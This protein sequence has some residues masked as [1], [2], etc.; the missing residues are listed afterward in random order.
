MKGLAIGGVLALLASSGVG[1]QAA[2]D[3][4]KQA[5]LYYVACLRERTAM[6]DDKVSDA[7]TI[8]AVVVPYCRTR[9][10]AYMQSVAP[11]SQVTDRLK[12]PASPA[13]LNAGVTVVLQHRAK[14]R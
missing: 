5:P 8:A 7:A 4:P 2:K 9:Q 13:D 1:A 3:Y 11:A 6:V 14:R 12:Q 10:L